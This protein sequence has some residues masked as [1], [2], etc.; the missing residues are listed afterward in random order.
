MD[1][2]FFSKHDR[3]QKETSFSWRKLVS[4]SRV[5][6]LYCCIPSNSWKNSL[7][8][9]VC[10][11]YDTVLLSCSNPSARVLITCLCVLL[12]FLLLALAP[13]KH[14]VFFGGHGGAGPRLQLFR[15]FYGNKPTYDSHTLVESE[16]N[17]ACHGKNVPFLVAIPSTGSQLSS[18]LPVMSAGKK[19]ERKN[20]C[21]RVIVFDA[22]KG[23]GENKE[24][25]AMTELS[26]YDENSRLSH[27]SF[28]DDRAGMWSPEELDGDL[29]P[30]DP[31]LS[32][33]KRLRDFVW[34]LHAM[35]CFDTTDAFLFLDEQVMPCPDAD[36]NLVIAKKRVSEIDYSWNT[37]RVAPVSSAL[38]VHKN[39]L[40][41]LADY[42]EG[43]VHLFH[44]L[45]RSLN[46]WMHEHQEKHFV[47]KHPLFH[48]SDYNCSAVMN[49]ELSGIE[50]WEAF[51]EDACEDAD[52]YPCSSGQRY[53]RFIEN[54]VSIRDSFAERM[55]PRPRA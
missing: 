28:V 50:K 14:A 44:T 21:T 20:L 29:N 40:E 48:T 3:T 32:E 39:A 46:E 26:N 31:A 49:T 43:N 27:V 18:L 23:A 22:G 38:L 2:P 12:A 4:I 52:T 51:S 34:M 16:L 13:W 45:Q 19:L 5:R 9:F 55:N 10:S 53:S 15:M 33:R 42:I 7:K 36:V 37:I 35:N 8:T 47:T 24:F 41:D 11:C 1:H 54:L 6:F 25:L 17:Q 30:R